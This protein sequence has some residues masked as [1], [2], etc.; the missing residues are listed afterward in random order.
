[1]NS[2]SIPITLTLLIF[3][4]S[5][6]N[7]YQKLSV[8]DKG[9]SGGNPEVN[10]Q[11]KIINECFSLKNKIQEACFNMFYPQNINIRIYP[12]T[13]ALVQLTS[14]GSLVKK[15][16]FN[17][18]KQTRFIVNINTS[19]IATPISCNSDSVK[20]SQIKDS[21]VIDLRVK[22]LKKHLIVKDKNG[23]TILD[24]TIIK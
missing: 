18:T 8:T 16:E 24:Y 2:I 23:Q 1:M 14:R 21:L 13:G 17:L 22:D 6:S 20:Y 12:P 5:C 9:G 19:K 10:N 11:I 4:T 7:S 15:R 3:T